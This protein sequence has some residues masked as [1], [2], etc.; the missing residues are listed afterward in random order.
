MAE[1]EVSFLLALITLL[2]PVYF[3]PTQVLA[4]VVMP[5]ISVL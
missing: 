5:G 1:P 4:S 2:S 3:A